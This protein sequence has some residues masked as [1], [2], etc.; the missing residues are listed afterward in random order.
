MALPNDTPASIIQRA[1]TL[2]YAVKAGGGN[3][4]KVE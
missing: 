4:I 3:S 2:M 1:D